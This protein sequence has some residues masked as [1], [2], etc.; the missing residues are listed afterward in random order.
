MGKP[1]LQYSLKGFSV[2]AVAQC[3]VRIDV[4]KQ[5][6]DNFVIEVYI[7]FMI[8]AVGSINIIQGGFREKVKEIS[9]KDF[10]LFFGLIT[11]FI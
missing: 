6:T 7:K 8:I 2:D 11:E 10:G 5:F 4:R 3:L 9:I 1:Y